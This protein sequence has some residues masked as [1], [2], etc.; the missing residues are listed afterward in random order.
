MA[1]DLITT[2]K[3]C[4]ELVDSMRDRINVANVTVSSTRPGTE[5]L[6]KAIEIAES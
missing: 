6:V 3:S 4:F 5:K 1:I 2:D